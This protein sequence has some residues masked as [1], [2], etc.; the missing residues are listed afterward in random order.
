MYALVLVAALFISLTRTELFGGPYHLS[1]MQFFV[2]PLVVIILACVL[3]RILALHTFFTITV[4][5][6]P[7]IAG[8]LVVYGPP[9]RAKQVVYISVSELDRFEVASRLFKEAV[10]DRNKATHASM[11]TYR[12]GFT[13]K[14]DLWRAYERGELERPLL[15]RQDRWSGLFIPPSVAQNFY[16]EQF[17][18]LRDLYGLEV[19]DN[20]PFTGASRAL[21]QGS[22]EFFALFVDALAILERNGSFTDNAELALPILYQAARLKY[23][24]TSQDHRAY[25]YWL[26]GNLHLALSLSR[27][28]ALSEGEISCALR[29][30][31]RARQLL[32]PRGS[33]RELYAAIIVNEGVARVMRQ[34][35]TTGGKKSGAAR[36]WSEVRGIFKGRPPQAFEASPLLRAKNNLVTIKNERIIE[37]AVA[38]KTLKTSKS[39]GK[40]KKQ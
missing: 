13:K 2:A 10:F 25:T 30:Y 40:K 14:E 9:S 5:V 17:T 32:N 7:L 19:V 34:K 39:Y 4:G 15:W 38:G 35:I 33:K 16:Q 12:S 6:M 21:S 8:A 31:A 22:E 27:G 20:V 11:R 1:L 28:S 36:L 24:W 23:P 18:K 26:I 29:S 3:H 37:R